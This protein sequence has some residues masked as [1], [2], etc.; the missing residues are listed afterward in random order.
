MGTD[1]TIWTRFVMIV[2]GLWMIAFPLTFDHHSQAMTISD[3]VSGAL[4]IVFGSVAVAYSRQWLLWVLCLIGVW[5]QFAPLAFWAP[6]AVSY[7]NDTV[8][9]VLVI[10]LSILLPR[11]AT[12]EQWE[13]EASI[14]PGWSYNPSAWQQRIPIVFFGFLAWMFAR[15]MAAYQLGYL[16]TVWDPI[17]GDGTEKVITS[18]VSK[19]FPV[20]DAGLG[21]MAY[22]FEVLM[23]VHGGTRRWHTIPWFVILFAILV[24]P[25]GFI[26]ILLIILQP[27]VV[28]HWCTWCLLTAVC[29]LTMIALAVDE[30]VAVLQ[31]L[32]KAR[33]EGKLKE[34]LWKG[35]PAPNAAVDDRTPEVNV[36]LR[37][38]LPAMVWGISV[39]F[40][41]VLTA[42]L[43]VWLMF[44]PSVLNITGAAADS[45]HI[46]GA[47]AVAISVI[48][49]AE[50]VRSGRY[51]LTLFGVWI[52]LSAWVLPGNAMDGM[53]SHIVTGIL[54]TLLSLPKGKI[55]ESYGSFE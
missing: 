54:L 33:K 5:L 4:L 32:S 49:M 55:K 13:S 47:L 7:V 44:S 30:V 18:S 3:I 24:I 1:K 26:S 15:Y 37:K 20:P 21:A 31:Y 45:D 43:G 40:N 36:S 48:T 35:G 8:V 34:V 42:L 53:I 38:S 6:E 19:D 50:V 10:S 17:F 46:I 14:P 23:A 25:L 2:L 16:N 29:M 22:T 12:E 41:L 28:G 27:I 51:I 39:P 9:G 11:N 52:F